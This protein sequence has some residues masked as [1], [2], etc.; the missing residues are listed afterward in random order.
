MAGKIGDDKD[1]ISAGYCCLAY[2]TEPGNV[3][4]EP[5]NII[6]VVQYTPF[7]HRNQ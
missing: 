5:Y 7:L 3:P 6:S 4:V 1:G 2:G